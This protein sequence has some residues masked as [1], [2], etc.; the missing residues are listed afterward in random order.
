MT[1]TVVPGMKGVRVFPPSPKGFD[2]L[3]ASRTD[4]ARH[5]IPPRP[6]P[7][8]Q[9]ERAALWERLARRY[10]SFEHL[11]PQLIPAD[12]RRRPRRWNRASPSY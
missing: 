3:A 7:G 6:D 1:E 8:T 4:L 10:G 12:T 9:P 11:K 2:A 5:G